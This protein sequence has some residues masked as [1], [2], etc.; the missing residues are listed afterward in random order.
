MNVHLKGLPLGEWRDLTDAEMEGI[1]KLIEHS[2]SEAN[3]APAKKKPVKP[4][5]AGSNAAFSKSKSTGRKD[6]SS[7]AGKPKRNFSDKS[8]KA[9]TKNRGRKR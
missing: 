2:K 8:G 6:A 4:K 3:P 1:F 9:A 5:T 7:H